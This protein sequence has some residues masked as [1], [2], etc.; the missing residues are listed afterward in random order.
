MFFA[1]AKNTQYADAVCLSAHLSTYFSPES[2]IL[3]VAKIPKFQ[4]QHPN[5]FWASLSESPFHSFSEILWSSFCFTFRWF[6]SI[7]FEIDES[8]VK[9]FASIRW[10]DVGS[11]C[12]SPFLW[13]EPAAVNDMVAVSKE[14]VFATPSEFWKF[15]TSAPIKQR[16]CMKVSVTK[17]FSWQRWLMSQARIILKFVN[18]VHGTHETFSNV[19]VQWIVSF[20]WGKPIAVFQYICHGGSHH[21]Y[22]H[23]ISKFPNKLPVYPFIVAALWFITSNCVAFNIYQKIRLKE[24]NNEVHIQSDFEALGKMKHN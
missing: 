22:V 7:P 14:I 15:I 4:N 13:T 12:W 23:F 10:S 2:L 11:I 19:I 24:R 5:T 1:T 16:A 20:I 9:L 6:S 17:Y 18:S 8:F 3:F 21:H